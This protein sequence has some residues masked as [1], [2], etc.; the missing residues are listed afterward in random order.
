LKVVASFLLPAA[1]LA[2]AA[3]AV[4]APGLFPASLPAFLSLFPWVVLAAGA[5]LAVR[6]R[7]GRALLAFVAVAAAD[8][9]LQRIAPAS[10]SGGAGRF[11]L[12][13]TALLLP[14]DLA[15]IA[16]LP[17]RSALSASVLGGLAALAAQPALLAFLWLSYHPGLAAALHRELVPALGVPGLP[18]AQPAQWGFAVA[19]V[20]VAVV[21]ARRGDPLAAGLEWA[22]AAAF[23]GLAAGGDARS[24]SVYLTAGALILATSLVESAFA[25]AY[26]DGLTGLPSRR[27]LDEA[28]AVTRGAFAVAMADIDHFKEVNDRWGHDV[29]DQVLRMVAARLAAVEGGRAFRYGGEEFALLFAGR[30]CAD[31]RGGLEA[32]RKAV[33]EAAFT[34][35][36]GDR[37]KRRPKQPRPTARQ[38]RI[39][40][41]ISIGAADSGAHRGRAEAVL[42]AADAALYRAKQEGRNRVVS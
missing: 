23:I 37:P 12:D 39:A 5:V 31:V 29:G 34:L 36:G 10:P 19:L 4:N 17:E 2:V 20:V 8:Q 27:A 40:V 22:L 16:L 26:R 30:S 14:L 13:A 1:L 9:L 11:A 15:A 41:T 21:W 35:R 38:V 42:K 28:I 32:L 7:R 24:A 33:A 18:L 6:F 25:L 3:L